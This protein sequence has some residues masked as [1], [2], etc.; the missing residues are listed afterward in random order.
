[1]KLSAI[2]KKISKLDRDLSKPKSQYLQA[3]RSLLGKETYNQER[4]SIFRQYTAKLELDQAYFALCSTN[5]DLMEKGMRYIM[6]TEVL[7]STDAKNVLLQILKEGTDSAQE[8]SIYLLKPYIHSLKDINKVEEIVFSRPESPKCHLV[9]A[10]S[11]LK[12]ELEQRQATA[13]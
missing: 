8:N 9:T 3:V 1:M 13:A 10:I 5:S 7:N 2:G 4:E 11:A 6:A 12:K